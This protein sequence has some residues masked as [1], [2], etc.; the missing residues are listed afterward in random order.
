M[1]KPWQVAADL[2]PDGI[3]APDKHPAVPHVC[4]LGQ[5][6]LGFWTRGLL[7]EL[8]HPKDIA[9]FD[10][11]SILA[12]PNIAIAGF[13][14]SRLNADGDQAVQRLSHNRGGIEHPQ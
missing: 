13:R 11:E 7:N 5:E 12:H 3:R 8:R 9:A 14:M 1:C 10:L 2:A 4:A 6:L